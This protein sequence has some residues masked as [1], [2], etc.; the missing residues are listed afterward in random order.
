MKKKLLFCIHN[1]FFLKHYI[2]DLKELEKYFEITII[3]SNYL[4]KNK[5]IEY[6]C[7]KKEFNFK[8][9]FIVPFYKK[10]LERSLLTIFQTHLFLSKLKKKSFIRRI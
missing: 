8:D 10:N 4:I 5:E 7:L 2:L 9:F 3:T 6:E 1:Y